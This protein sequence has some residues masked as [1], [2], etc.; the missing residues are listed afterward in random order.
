M[1]DSEIDPSAIEIMAPSTSPSAA[2]KYVALQLHWYATMGHPIHMVL[3]V[4]GTAAV[5]TAYNRT[6][7][8]AVAPTA[9]FQIGGANAVDG[10]LSVA[11]TLMLFQRGGIPAVQ[12]N[13]AGLASVATHGY[14][15]LIW[16][17]K[18]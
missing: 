15:A 14:G 8:P 16:P 17:A 12:M 4:G 18:H 5:S 11:D 2:A 9:T 1:I 6:I 7:A 13:L 10:T 3:T